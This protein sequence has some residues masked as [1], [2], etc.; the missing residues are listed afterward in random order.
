MSSGR[1]WYA[2]LGYASGN[3]GKSL[4]NTTV[5]LVYLY[6]LIQ[7]LGVPAAL[8]GTVLL[9]SQL[10]E[11]VTDPVLGHLIDR[12]LGSRRSYNRI[13]LFALPLSALSF[14]G[15]FW[16]PSVAGSATGVWILIS[17]MAFRL[18]YALVDVPHN[19]LLAALSSNSRRCSELAAL[20]FLFSSAGSLA[21]FAF[22]APALESQRD[23]DGFISFAIVLAILYCVVMTISVLSTPA[24]AAAQRVEPPQDVSGTLKHL[25]GNRRLMRIFL[26]CLISAALLTM[27]SRMTAFYATSWIGDAKFASWLLGAHFVGQLVSAP[28]WSFIGARHEKKTAAWCAHLLM[29]LVA[30]G[31]LAVAPTAHFAGMFFYFWAGVAL[32]GF[33]IMNWALVPD[34]IEY[35]AARSGARHEA[36]TF[37]IF[38][39]LNKVASGIGMALIGWALH[40]SGYDVEAAGS[41]ARSP[42]LLWAMTLPTI[43][44][45]LA[46]AALL[47][48]LSMSH[49]EVERWKEPLPSARDS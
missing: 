24:A 39:A 28:V 12:K 10:W 36:T 46:C 20:R 42:E 34:A 4:Q 31:F 22:A 16:L 19:A 33:T 25:W 8:A 43:A 15:I 5:G 40:F 30:V 1:G 37:G 9:L 32:S 49:A 2:E 41:D 6:F 23:P 7:V 48:R 38:T 29:V 14:I 27:F 47:S 13:I 11:C 21:V 44:G 3:F 17:C 35:T 26:V 18:A 45:A